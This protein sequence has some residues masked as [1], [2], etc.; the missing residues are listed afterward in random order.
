MIDYQSVEIGNLNFAAQG[1]QEIY[2]NLKI[3][4]TTP[5]GSVPFDRSFGIETS[6]L[7]EPYPI[8]KGRLTVEYIQKTRLYEPRANVREVLFEHDINSGVL[9]P[10]VVIDIDIE[11]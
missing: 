3:L 2:E 10:K 4:Y 9:I 7:D 1:S 5:M 11:A 6:F 8:A